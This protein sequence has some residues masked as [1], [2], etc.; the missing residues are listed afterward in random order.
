MDGTPDIVEA[1]GIDADQNGRMDNFFDTDQD[2]HGNTT[3]PDSGNNPWPDMDSDADNV[4]NRLDVDSDNDGITD[5]AE[6]GGTDSDANGQV[7]TYEDADNDGYAAL[8]DTDEGGTALVGRD[9]DGDQIQDRNDLDSD[10]DGITDLIEAKGV[11]TDKDGFVDEFADTDGDGYADAFDAD[12]GGTPLS[13]YDS[14]ADGLDNN[15]DIDSDNDAL[16]DLLEAGG[17]DADGDGR[18]DGFTDN[19]GNGL[20]R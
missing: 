6:S 17:T 20:C 10:N 12:N 1:G 18:V 8:F 2:G 4:P 7:D 16:T 14:D 9:T 15:I 11:D 3:D 5:L 13:D 19:N